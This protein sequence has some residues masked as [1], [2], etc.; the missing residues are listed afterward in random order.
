MGD[1]RIDKK[2]ISHLLDSF[3]HMISPGFLSQSPVARQVAVI[4]PSGNSPSSHLKVTCVLGRAGTE[5]L[6]M[7]PFCGGD[8]EVVQFIGG[9]GDR[10]FS[11]HSLSFHL[12]HKLWEVVM[13]LV[14]HYTQGLNSTSMCPRMSPL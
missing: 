6:L 9:A 12:T 1:A 4:I 14:T 7:V 8:S 11:I 2:I 3:L 13:W 5:W 10:V